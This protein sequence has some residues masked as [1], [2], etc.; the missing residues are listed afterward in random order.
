MSP[1]ITDIIRDLYNG[2]TTRASPQS[3]LT[4]PIHIRTGVKQGCPLSPIIF[5]LAIE[6]L[7]REIRAKCDATCYTLTGGKKLQMMVYAGDIC[8]TASSPNALHKPY[9]SQVK[10]LRSVAFAS[11]HRSA[12]PFILIVRKGERSSTRVLASKVVAL[13]C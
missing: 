6:P 9:L 13:Q 1:P 10:R 3:G 11:S 8:V 12:L 5:N 7:L 2:A 4:E